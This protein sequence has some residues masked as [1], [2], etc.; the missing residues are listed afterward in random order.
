MN[1]KIIPEF[2]YD[3]EKESAL[4][5]LEESNNRLKEMLSEVEGVNIEY[6]LFKIIFKI[7]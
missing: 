1:D 4:K 7:F 6:K 2:I 3:D 5:K